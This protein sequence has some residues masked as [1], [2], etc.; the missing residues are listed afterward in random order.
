MHFHL[1]KLF[2]LFDV[3]FLSVFLSL[4]LELLISLY[5]NAIKQFNHN[6][7]TFIQLTV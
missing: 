1:G 7:Q 2:S 3:T 6:T 5:L 4:K